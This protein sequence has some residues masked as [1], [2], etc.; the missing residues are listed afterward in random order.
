MRYYVLPYYHGYYSL[1]W[2][3]PWKQHT[4]DTR[5]CH[6]CIAVLLW[7]SQLLLDCI[8]NDLNCLHFTKRYVFPSQTDKM[9]W[10]LP[11]VLRASCVAS[12]TVHH[13]ITLC[14]SVPSVPKAIIMVTSAG[15]F[16]PVGLMGDLLEV[17]NLNLNPCKL[18]ND[19]GHPLFPFWTSKIARLELKFPKI[20]DTKVAY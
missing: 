2:N 18:M 6:A 15:T 1:E 14:T 7:H 16:I 9:A 12:T 3:S 8:L 20:P 11:G 4:T 19:Q 13:S 10:R 17:L 5:V